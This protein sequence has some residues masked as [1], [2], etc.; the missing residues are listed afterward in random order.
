MDRN[1]GLLNQILHMIG[2]NFS[3]EITCQPCE[4]KTQN[5]L[6]CCRI[7]L[8]GP[9]HKGGNRWVINTHKLSSPAPFPSEFLPAFSQQNVPFLLVRPE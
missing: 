9:R 4:A 6:M 1:Q 5:S 8:L 7:A 3:A 2:M